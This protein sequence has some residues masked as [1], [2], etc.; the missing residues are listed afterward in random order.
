MNSLDHVSRTADWADHCSRAG[1]NRGP[2]GRQW[3]IPA[4][5][6]RVRDA[7]AAALPGQ[8]FQLL[9]PQPTGEQPFLRRP[10]S[11]YGADAARHRIDFLYKAAGAGTRG[12]DML[13]VGDTL[14][15]HGAA[16]RWFH[17]GFRPAEHCGRRSWCRPC[18]A[19]PLARASRA[20]G[21]GV[22]AILSA[23]RP[24]L[25]MSIELF[26]SHGAEVITVTDSEQT[27]GPANVE[28]ILRQLIAQ[29]RC[30]GFLPAAPAGYC[31]CNSGSPMN[32]VSPGR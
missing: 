32:S 19:G 3:R 2:Y 4:P 28:R 29:D 23:R 1:A 5:D 11:V 25:L 12:L 24:D 31:A 13:R 9:C 21:I 27:S 10:M 17:A 15:P 8:F 16:G 14:D 22:T 6:R 26:E 18:D 7:A 30:D 20:M